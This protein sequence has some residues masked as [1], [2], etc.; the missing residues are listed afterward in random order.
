MR[1]LLT[2]GAGFIGH[3]IVEHILKKTDWE[4]VLLDRLDLSGNLNRVAD[5]MKSNVGKYQK[6][7]QWVYHD[8]RAPISQLTARSIG[9]ADIILHVGASTHVDRSIVDPVSFV[10]D[11]VVGTANILE[12]MRR[13]QARSTM[14]YFST[15][16]VFGPADDGVAFKEWDR[17]KS[18]NPYAAT[19]AGAEELCL[20][21]A[22]T[23]DL[24]IRITHCMNV[25]GERQHSEKFIPL[26]MHNL[27]FGKKTFIHA[28]KDK[29]KAGSRFYIH[30]RNVA[31]AV[32][33]VYQHGK[34]G[35]KY[36]IVGSEEVDNLTLALRIAKIVGN[37]LTYELVDFHSSRPGHDLRYALSGEKM[38]SM[39]WEPPVDF[40]VSLEKTVRWT[41]EHLEWL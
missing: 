19:K 9:D 33:F 1:V 16:E 4:I 17:Y 36:N 12:Y 14:I 15:D 39:G 10:H 38:K 29:T 22:N 30:A 18:G 31:D 7:L 37:P 34:K 40:D 20:A 3:H 26:V 8:F 2:G 35:D 13:Y 23:Y 6:R 32:L 5:V 24:D 21:F 11:N 27:I 28:N 25:F 41:M